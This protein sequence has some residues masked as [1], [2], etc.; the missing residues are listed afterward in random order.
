MLGVAGLAVPLDR[1][2]GPGRLNYG[3]P[4]AG[5]C[6][7][8]LKRYAPPGGKPPVAEGA[9]SARAGEKSVFERRGNR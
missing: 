6:P 8:W 1:M 4:A 9:A 2:V 3:R 5:A 7:R